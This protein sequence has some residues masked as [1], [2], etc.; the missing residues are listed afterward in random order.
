LTDARDCWRIVSSD[1]RTDSEDSFSFSALFFFLFSFFF[2]ALTWLDEMLYITWL[3][4]R[5][6]MY[7][8]GQWRVSR[9]YAI[10][11]DLIVLSHFIVFT[12]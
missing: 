11:L 6:N 3:F 5:M 10:A 2:G 7:T 1:G 9:S 8:M 4:V 12:D